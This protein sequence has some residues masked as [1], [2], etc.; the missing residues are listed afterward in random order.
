MKIRSF[1]HKISKRLAKE[2]K[3][4]RENLDKDIHDLEEKLLN[5]IDEDALGKLEATKRELG[6]FYSY[7][8]E[9]IKIRSRASWYES[10]E[11]DSRYFSQLMHANKKKSTIKKLQNLDGTISC[12]ESFIMKEIRQFY[13]Q[14]YSEV[15]CTNAQDK[16]SIF[17]QTLP[18]L[19]SESK[20]HCEGRIR[21]DECLEVLKDMKFNKSPGNDGLTVE[22]YNTFWPIVGGIVIDA[23]N[24]AY[25]LGEVPYHHLKNKL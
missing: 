16:Y 4:K 14:L 23:L 20:E 9:G 21:N 8:N 12:D 7:S 17:F 1:T 19:S 22:F 13:T 15:K 2:R 3:I 5:G 6:E 11:R 10:G 24:E 18:K 25:A